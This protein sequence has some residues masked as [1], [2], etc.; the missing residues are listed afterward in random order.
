M[1]SGGKG[2]IGPWPIERLGEEHLTALGLTVEGLKPLRAKYGRHEQ[3]AAFIT[4]A[5]PV[6]TRRPTRASYNELCR[7]IRQQNDH[8]TGFLNI[9]LDSVVLPAPTGET[10]PVQDWADR[11]PSLPV[12]L[13]LRLKAMAGE[14]LVLQKKV[15]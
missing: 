11:F 12:L 15:M 3:L 6:V 14:D 8:S 7:R 5:G 10:N 13:G 1:G 9:C 2:L 4:A